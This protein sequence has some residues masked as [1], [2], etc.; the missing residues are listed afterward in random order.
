MIRAWVLRKVGTLSLVFNAMRVIALLGFRHPSNRVKKGT[1][2]LNFAVEKSVDCVFL[3]FIGSLSL[4][5][6]E[7]S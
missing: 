1:S 6:S 7:K 2:R 5:N 4:D 3:Q